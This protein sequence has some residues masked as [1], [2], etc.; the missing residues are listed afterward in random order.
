MHIFDARDYLRYTN[1]IFGYQKRFFKL[2]KGTIFYFLSDKVE[3]DGCRKF[4]VLQ[5][6]E[7]VLDDF[8]ACRLDICFTDE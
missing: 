8:D 7:L 3:S 6:F 4:R 2:R 1:V 5:N